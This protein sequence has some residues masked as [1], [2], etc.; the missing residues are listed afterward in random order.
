MNKQL[1]NESSLQSQ[2]SNSEAPPN[3][4]DRRRF[5]SLVSV[6][7][8]AAVLA[9]SN[10]ATPTLEAATPTPPTATAQPV[11]P[12]AAATAKPSPWFK[13]TTPFIVQGDKV[14]E[15]RLENLQGFITP[16]E[17]FF[18]RNHSVSLDVDVKSWRLI[19]E[20]DAV[21][22]PLELTYEEILNLPS[23]TI[24]SY[25]ECAGNQRAMFELVKGQP[26]EG[27]QWKTGGISNGEWTGV[28]L[29]DVLQLAGIKKNAVD[30]LLVGLDKASPEEGVRRAL[31]V[32]KALHPDTLLAYALNGE[33]LP[34]DHGFPLRGL[35]P[36]WVGVSSIKW[37]GRIVVSSEKF[38]GRN[39]TTNYVLIGKDYP[40]EG[41]AQGEPVTTQVIKSALALPWPATFSA[42]THRIHGY[43]QSP[44]GPIKQVEWSTDN[45][46]TWHAATLLEP[47]I[48]YSWARF[49]F[50]WTAKPGKFTILTRATDVAGN[51]Q[52]D[53]IPLNNQGYL[54]NQPVPHPITVA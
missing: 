23:R 52:P 14:L 36:G 45:G 29:R 16:T 42:G 51:T 20:G 54:F 27:T 5:L 41:K 26:A 33:T 49:E 24:F 34:K 35:A 6:G 40:A 1:P 47:Q 44:A 18:V 53:D 4:V 10:G 9:V 11:S 7:S 3:S 25:L 17:D 48:Q 38:W 13:E 31:P 2:L 8:A 30:V 28:A 22:K 15:T 39:N 21:A 32:E 43:A 37:L 50:T 12:L 46:K 19:V